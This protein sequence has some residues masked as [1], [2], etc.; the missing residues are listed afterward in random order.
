[1]L[2]ARFDAL[3]K[4]LGLFNASIIVTT[5]HKII[6]TKCYKVSVSPRVAACFTYV[7]VYKKYSATLSI[8]ERS[9]TDS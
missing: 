2:V 8:L 5:L 9:R 3:A 6:A 7:P 4:I 1:M